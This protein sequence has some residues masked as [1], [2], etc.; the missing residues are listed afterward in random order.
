MSEEEKESGL[1]KDLQ[2]DA[3]RRFDKHFK[4]LN[5]NIGWLALWAKITIAMFLLSL[6]LTAI[7]AMMLA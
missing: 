3:I 2:I 7:V 4:E 5:E 1:D 6:I